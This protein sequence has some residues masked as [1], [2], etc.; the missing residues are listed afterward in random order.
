MIH[1]GNFLRAI[2]AVLAL[3]ACHAALAERADRNKPVQIEADRVTVNE[4]DKV[5]T[6]EGNV[7]LIQGTTALH[8]DK[9]VVSQ[10]LEGFQNGVVTGNLAH[11]RSKR[12]GKNAY[13]N[14]EAERIVHD[15]KTELTK[16]FNR[17]HIKSGQ[18]EV[19]GEYIEYNGRTDNYIV[20][21][22]PGGTVLPVTPAGDNRVRVVIQPKKKENGAEP[23]GEVVPPTLAPEIADPKQ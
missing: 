18:D 14:G 7:S 22:G 19:S 1:T 15:A 3:L 10:S 9:V 5:Q 6:F 4:A 11:F 23:N 2:L 12:E 20:T 21:S 16:F 17:A 13:I 8:G